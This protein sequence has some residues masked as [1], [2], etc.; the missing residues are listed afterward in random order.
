[1]LALGIDFGTSGTRACIIDA[2]GNELATSSVSGDSTHSPQT[3]WQEQTPESWWQSLTTVIKQLP[4]SL[5]ADISSIAIDGTSGSVLLCDGQGKPTTPALMYH[6]TRATQQAEQIK[7]FAPKTSGAQGVSS[8]LAKWLW[9]HQSTGNNPA[10]RP[11]HQAD[12]IANRLCNQFGISDYNNVLKL[13]YDPVNEVWPEWLTQLKL[14]LKQLPKVIA[15]GDEMGTIDSSI[16]KALGLSNSVSIRA[17]STDSIAAF[18]ATGANNSGDAV[19][20]LGSTLVT[21]VISEQPIFSAK[22]GVYSHKFGNRWLAGGASNSGGAALLKHFSIEEIRDL[23]SKINPEKPTGLNYYPLPEKGERFPINDPD[24]QTRLNPNLSNQPVR[25]LQGLLE[26][27]ANI[28]KL[29]YQRLHQLGA[30]QPK[31][32]YT[33]GGGAANQPWQLIRQG[34]LPCPI[35]KSKHSEAAYGAALIAVTKP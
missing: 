3:G 14:P 11:L 2:Q 13:G 12:W 23:S 27:I 6:D 16:A 29:A 20:S 4:Q 22:Y 18:I 15:P 17:G 31:Q 35:I 9:L 5:R 7:A 24:M 8:S 1:M 19:T 30:P 34:L 25:F 28:E 21:K 26:G 10:L 32:I 33:A